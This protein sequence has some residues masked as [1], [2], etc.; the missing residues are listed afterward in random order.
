MNIVIQILISFATSTIVVFVYFLLRRRFT[1]SKSSDRLTPLERTVHELTTRVTSLE[2]YCSQPNDASLIFMSKHQTK[3]DQGNRGEKQ[4]LQTLDNQENVRQEA[5]IETK[6][7]ATQY[8]YLSVSEG[9]LVEVTPG[10]ASYYRAWK[11]KGRILFEFFCDPQKVKKVIN[12]RS[13]IIDPCCVKADSSKEPDNASSIVIVR[14][15]ELD[16]SFR[17]KTKVTIKFS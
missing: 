9:K 17:I 7:I 8:T 13:A 3:D 14:H 10:Q 12:N 6:P 11:H 4:K 15:G 1:R 2:Q 16:D 5:Q